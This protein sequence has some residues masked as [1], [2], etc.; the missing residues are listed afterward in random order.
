MVRIRV[1]I[2]DKR[3]A[4]YGIEPER[5]HRTTRP[6][7]DQPAEAWPVSTIHEGFIAN[8]STHSSNQAV[9]RQDAKALGQPIRQSNQTPDQVQ[10]LHPFAQSRTL[11]Q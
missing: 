4:R 2:M 11:R 3:V 9:T 8:H 6:T 10:I 5:H 7:H 1:R